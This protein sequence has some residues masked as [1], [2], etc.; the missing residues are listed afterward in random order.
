M[1]LD[2]LQFYATLHHIE[3]VLAEIQEHQWCSFDQLDVNHVVGGEFADFTS[4]E[5]I[6]LL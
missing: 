6:P 5:T 2:L 3:K 4:V 1:L